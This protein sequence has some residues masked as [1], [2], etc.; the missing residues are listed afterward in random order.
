MKDHWKQEAI[1]PRTRCWAQGMDG[2]K[3]LQAVSQLKWTLMATGNAVMNESDLAILILNM[4][5]KICEYFPS[6]LVTI[7]SLI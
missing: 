2:W 3:P 7:E 4:L 5:I 6:R 1:N